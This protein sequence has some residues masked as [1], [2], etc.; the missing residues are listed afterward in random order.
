MEKV[1]QPMAVGTGGARV[2]GGGGAGPSTFQRCKKINCE[3][4]LE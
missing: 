4:A 2:G 3:N 1:E